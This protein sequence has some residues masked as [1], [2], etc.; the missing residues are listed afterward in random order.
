[1]SIKVCGNGGRSKF[2]SQ[3]E[4]SERVKEV[5]QIISREAQVHEAYLSQDE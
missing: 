2:N 4:R 3:S 1:M 5:F